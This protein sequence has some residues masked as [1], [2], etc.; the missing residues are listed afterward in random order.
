MTPNEYRKK[1]KRCA[2]CEYFIQ[3]VGSRGECEVKCIKRHNTDGMF[4]KVY[5]A[6]EFKEND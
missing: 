1:H 5:K 2:T 4:C 6:K 3:E